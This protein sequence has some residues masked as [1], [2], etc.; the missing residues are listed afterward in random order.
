MKQVTKDMLQ[1]WNMTDVDWM[2]Y[3]KGDNDIWSFHHLLIPN[4]KGGPYA[5]WNG[6]ILCGKTSHP[7]LHIIEKYDY[8]R[9]LYITGLLHDEN[10]LR[11]LDLATIEEIDVVLSGFEREY[12]GKDTKKKRRIIKPE[13][14]IRDY[15]SL[16]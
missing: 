6:A 15:T 11:R 2:G 3:K 1:I 8:E 13:Y 10:I 16:R 9:F 4:R 14:T 5:I 12:Q 7:Y